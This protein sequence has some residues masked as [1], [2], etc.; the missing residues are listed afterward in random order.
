LNYR[1][2]TPIVITE[3][4]CD[5]IIGYG[6][7][8]M[9]PYLGE[10]HETVLR[11][12]SKAEK[13]ISEYK[14]PFYIESIL[15]SIDALEEKNTAAKA[16]IDI[17]L[18]DLKG[19]ME[20]RPCYSFWNLD[21]N[22]TPDTSITIGMDEPEVII[23][24]LKEAESFKILKIKLGSED[25]KKIIETIRSFTQ[26]PIS[27]DVNQGWKTKEAALEMIHWLNERN[28]LFVEQP[29]KKEDLSDAA[30]LTERSPLP[31]IAD[32]SLQ[33]FADL[34]QIKDCFHGIN[35]KLMKCTG[36]HEAYKIIAQA[37]KYNLKVLIGCMSETTCA[38]SA[39]AQLSPLV[40]WADLDGPLLIKNDLFEGVKFVEG[41]LELQDA[42]GIGVRR[43]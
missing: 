5:G 4:I 14:T 16:S 15:G 17:A 1:T 35:V 26:K 3:I 13:I 11:F 37:R 7:A 12:L 43:L 33:R 27:V 6:E 2:S 8:S 31:L 10:S 23:K 42:P 38:I 39:A 22:K 24:K 36:I 34:G 25:D 40:D 18:H 41:R 29:L 21:K 32:E 30:W 28:V 9:P 19:K 20:G